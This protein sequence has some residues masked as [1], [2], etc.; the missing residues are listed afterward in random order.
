MSIIE[1]IGS[2]GTGKSD[3]EGYERAWHIRKA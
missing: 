3:R 2:S 1:I